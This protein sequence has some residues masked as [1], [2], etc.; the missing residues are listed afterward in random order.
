VAAIAIVGG[1]G[2]SARNLNAFWANLAGALL[3]AIVCAVPILMNSTMDRGLQIAKSSLAGPFAFLALA[4]IILAAG[5]RW[6]TGA[7][8]WTRAA[9]ISLIVFVLLAVMS[10]LLS[11]HPLVA[12]FGDYGT[13]EGLLA[14]ATYA[15]MFFAVLGWATTQGTGGTVRLVDLMLLASVVP[16]GYAIQQRSGLDFLFYAYGDPTRSH[17]TLGSPLFLGAYLATILP[18][19]VVRGWL[20]RRTKMLGFWLCLGALQLTALLL[21]Q[22]RGPVIAFVL[23]GF[24]LVTLA[25]GYKGNRRIFAALAVV[26]SASATFL[27]AINS[28]PAA[29]NVAEG[30]PVLSRFVYRVE[31]RAASETTALALRSNTARLGVWEAASETFIDAPMATRLIGF[32]PELSYTHHYQFLPDTVLQAEGFLMINAFDRYHADSLDIALNYGALA[33]VAYTGF[34]AAAVFAGA[35]ALFGVGGVVVAAVFVAATLAGATIGVGLVFWVGL[36]FAAAPAAGLGIGGGWMVFLA[37]LAWRAI[38]CGVP[39]AARIQPQSW[40]L[41]AGLLC[42]LL[43]FW[44]DAQVNIPILTTRLISFCV[45]ALALVTSARLRVPPSP[46]SRVDTAWGEGWAVALPAVAACV[47]FLPALQIDPALNPGREGRWWLAAL[48]VILLLAFAGWRACT[49]CSKRIQIA[50]ALRESVVPASIAITLYSLGHWTLVVTIGPTIKDGDTVRLVLLAAFGIVFLLGGCALYAYRAPA[51]SLVGTIPG[52]PPFAWP[53]LIMAGLVAGHAATEMRAESALMLANWASISQPEVCD[54]LLLDSIAAAPY[55]RQ[56]QRRRTF[57]HLGRAVNEISRGVPT[58]NNFGTIRHELEVAE[59]QAR[60]SLKQFPTDPWLILA[61]G[62]VLQIE[63]LASFRPLAPEWGRAAAMEADEVFRHMYDMAPNQP[64]LLQSWAQLRSNEGD[65]WGA[66]QLI[67]R[68]ETV[69]PNDPAPYAERIALAKR[70]NNLELASE[71][72]H[73]ARDRLDSEKFEKLLTV[74][75]AQQN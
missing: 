56:Y 47:S 64:L 18:L 71:T 2:V 21:T 49:G 31:G 58:S 38:R 14:W 24:L 70:I 8:A 33:W 10:T 4:C 57:E 42:S 55:E 66:L 12:T 1:S 37:F 40:A 23:C 19:T 44:L 46:N 62:N 74:V 17:G 27:A 48:P 51:E 61:L 5:G 20:E 75:R 11:E 67:D 73:R 72:L 25:A 59:E 60:S 32:G 15:A 13:R 41:L 28:L 22:S 9:T 52:K 7:P 50:A 45:A 63:A 26:V 3:M 6:L 54:R 34:F 16:A 69:I 36:P 68:M 35:C 29:R 30:L 43:V 65:I 39:E 53:F